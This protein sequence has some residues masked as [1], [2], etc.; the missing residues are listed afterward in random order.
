M[1]YYRNRNRDIKNTLGMFKGMI[2]R[3]MQ[4]VLSPAGFS[5]TPVSPNF[6]NS[7]GIMPVQQ[8][9]TQISTQY[10]YNYYRNGI[11]VRIT[12][13]ENDI[14]KVNQILNN[15]FN[16]QT[17]G[18]YGLRYFPISPII[19][20]IATSIQLYD[21]SDGRP[22]PVIN[23]DPMRLATINYNYNTNG[24]NV[25]LTGTQEDIITIK[26]ILDKKLVNDIKVEETVTIDNR[27]FYG[28]GVM[29]FESDV[30][31][32]GK[33]ILNVLLVG[34]PGENIY[35]DFGGFLSSVVNNENNVLELNAKSQLKSNS[36]IL[37]DFDNV[38]LTREIEEEKAYID[39]PND[40][41]KYFRCYIIC[42]DRKHGGIAE[43]FRYNQIIIN[44]YNPYGIRNINI[45]IRVK[46]CSNF[47]KY[48]N[49]TTQK[50]TDEN[51]D[52][53][54]FSDRAKKIFKEFIKNPTLIRKLRS[55]PSKSITI[56]N[57]TY[58]VIATIKIQ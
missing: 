32:E 37:F 28:S 17:G 22:G 54:T 48:I 45:I 44:P 9:T 23:L 2:V 35:N 53:R 57:V 51:G 52:E 40:D 33:P 20:P 25:T 27:K 18:Q 47:S 19:A 24:I 8:V 1:D 29:I 15:H 56:P 55:K 7:Y 6:N 58:G 46:I 50:C 13:S 21:S 38:K 16:P 12:G 41:G 42:L 39:V 49:G 14:N 11:N 26:E 31:S 30:N 34:S 36:A 3:E 4:P 43:G 5:Y 10:S